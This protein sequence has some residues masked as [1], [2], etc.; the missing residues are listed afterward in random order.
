MVAGEWS[1]SNEESI[2][3]SRTSGRGDER[4]SGRTASGGNAG[5]TQRQGTATQ[6]T[7]ATEASSGTNDSSVRGDQER[8]LRTS[9]EQGNMRPGTSGQRGNVGREGRG[10]TAASSGAN[11]T[12][13]ALMRRM[14][15]DM[16]RLFSDFGF[17]HPGT[18]GSSQANAE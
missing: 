17:T 1:G 14:M 8:E 3:A 6:G 15:E 7:A 18:F 4:S 12:P 16:D 2:M 11:N 13:F 9:N 10:Y 5:T